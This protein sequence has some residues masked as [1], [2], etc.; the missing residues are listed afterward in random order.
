MKPGKNNEVENR[1]EQKPQSTFF[2]LIHDQRGYFISKLKSVGPSVA[3]AKV[4]ITAYVKFAVDD[5]DQL[6]REICRTYASTIRKHNFIHLVSFYATFEH[7]FTDTHE[8][9]QTLNL[10]D[11]H[12]NLVQKQL[13]TPDCVNKKF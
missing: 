4:R 3:N 2:T 5:I 12:I 7:N 1:K 11:A 13:L 9:H 8:S 6:V 10:N